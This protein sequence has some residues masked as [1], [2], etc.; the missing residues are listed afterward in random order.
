MEKTLRFLGLAAVVGACAIVMAQQNVFSPARGRDQQ[1]PSGQ[2][3]T[4]VANQGGHSFR[5]NLL[6]LMSQYFC[7]KQS[8][9]IEKAEIAG[10]QDRVQ[11]IIH[12]T[13][14]A[15][16]TLL[17][18]D[19]QK[20]EIAGWQ[21]DVYAPG[22]QAWAKVASTRT[23]AKELLNIDSKLDAK[24]DKVIEDLWKPV[25]DPENAFARQ[26]MATDE[27][28]Q[29]RTQHER[30]MVLYNARQAR[31][32]KN[33]PPPLIDRKQRAV[34]R[35]EKAMAAARLLLN[36]TQ[37]AEFDMIVKRFEVSIAAAAAGEVSPK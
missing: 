25:M 30:N 37:Q 2:G 32:A 5:N 21:L 15:N 23:L 35:N 28:K 36:K 8:Y 24:I 6:V 12:A 17:T 26:V 3:G 11:P 14:A 22:S 31:D 9:E 18:P 33:P 10:L 20:R 7:S 4:A 13:C 27:Y 29:A 1:Q 16:L 34:E 19:A